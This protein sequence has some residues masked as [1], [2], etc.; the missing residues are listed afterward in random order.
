[1]KKSHEKRHISEK[2]VTKSMQTTST[3]KIFE[4]NSSFHVK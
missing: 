2:K 3:D 1:M 4:K